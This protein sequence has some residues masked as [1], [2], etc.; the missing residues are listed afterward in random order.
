MRLQIW[1]DA[2]PEPER[3]VRLR[4]VSGVNRTIEVVAVD[5][6]GH[7]APGGVILRISEDGEIYR[8]PCVDS[9]L[10][11]TLDLVGRV[12]TN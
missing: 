5:A 10:G 9:D 7:M 3:V 1:N 4:L 6:Y 12:L 8:Y 2:T 11:F